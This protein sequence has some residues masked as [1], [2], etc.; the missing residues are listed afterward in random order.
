[1][2]KRKKN[3]FLVVLNSDKHYLIVVGVDDT[4]TDD[5]KNK[6]EKYFR[7]KILDIHKGSVSNIEDVYIY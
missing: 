5:I 6:I 7:A 1:M 2:R 3:I 4:I